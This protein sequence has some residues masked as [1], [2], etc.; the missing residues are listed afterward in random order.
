MLRD[1]SDKSTFKKPRKK[2]M[3]ASYLV[4]QRRIPSEA[5][6]K[7]S[8]ENQRNSV[9]KRRQGLPIQLPLKAKNSCSRIELKAK[10]LSK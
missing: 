4:R 1:Q 10:K 6:K 5:R 9:I 7:I 3:K 2:E 8:L